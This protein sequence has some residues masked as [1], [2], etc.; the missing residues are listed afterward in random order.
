[1]SC[2]LSDNL[3]PGSIDSDYR[4]CRGIG[5]HRSFRQPYRNKQVLFKQASVKHWVTVQDFTPC[6]GSGVQFS[7]AVKCKI[8]Y[9]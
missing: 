7:F 4:V 3:N 9:F 5:N 8:V 1:M 6:Q 2:I